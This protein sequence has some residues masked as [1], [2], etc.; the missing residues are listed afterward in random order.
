MNVIIKMNNKISLIQQIANKCNLNY[1]SNIIKIKEQT[2]KE[3][4]V[5]KYIMSKNI[6]AYISNNDKKNKIIEEINTFGSTWI[7]N[8]K[9]LEDDETCALEKSLIPLAEQILNCIRNSSNIKDNKFGKIQIEQ[10]QSIKTPAKMKLKQ[11]NITPELPLKKEN[12]F[13]DIMCKMIDISII[14]KEIKNNM[15]TELYKLGVWWRDYAMCT[16]NSFYYITEDEYD[17]YNAFYYPACQ[18]SLELS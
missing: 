17:W 4:N 13:I 7:Q 6:E 15:I 18:L 8:I 2:R 1:I 16:V 3:E 12:E 14:D 11:K 9:D 5:F 10:H